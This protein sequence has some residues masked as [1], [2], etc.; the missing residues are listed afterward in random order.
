M[1]INV[2]GMKNACSQGGFRSAI[3][4]FNLVLT[5]GAHIYRQMSKVRILTL[6]PGEAG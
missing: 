4:T 6:F 2:H 5:C 1:N 3:V